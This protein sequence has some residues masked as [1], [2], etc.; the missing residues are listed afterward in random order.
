LSINLVPKLNDRLILDS[1]VNVPDR[2]RCLCFQVFQTCP[3]KKYLQC[4]MFMF[5]LFGDQR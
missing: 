4:T 5:L 2:Q 1:Q 3:L